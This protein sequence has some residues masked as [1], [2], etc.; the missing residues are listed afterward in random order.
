VRIVP[1][2]PIGSL[3]RGTT[4]LLGEPTVNG[5]N[6]LPRNTALIAHSF[7]AV[8]DPARRNSS[9]LR[10]VVHATRSESCGGA[11]GDRSAASVLR[12]SPKKK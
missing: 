7:G 11:S 8:P 4:G 5:A 1:V 12:T 2:G 3:G 9:A 10:A 6:Q